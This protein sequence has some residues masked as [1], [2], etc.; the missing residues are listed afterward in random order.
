MPSRAHTLSRLSPRTLRNRAQHVA[1]FGGR[2]AL[3]HYCE[4]PVFAVSYY[5]V[6]TKNGVVRKYWRDV[7]RYHAAVFLDR[8]NARWEGVL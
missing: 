7:C 4:E 1:Q 3:C 5:E 2:L 8:H 6:V